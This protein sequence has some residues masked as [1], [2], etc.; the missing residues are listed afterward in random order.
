M[1][2]T[3]RIRKAIIAVLMLAAIGTGGMLFYVTAGDR[4]N[5]KNPD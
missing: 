2:V 4:P 1:L 5:A 3:D